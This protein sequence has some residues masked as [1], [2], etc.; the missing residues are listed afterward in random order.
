[1][2]RA[3]SRELFLLFISLFILFHLI[4]L[5]AY[6]WFLVVVAVVLL[7][8]SISGF[9]LVLVFRQFG[10]GIPVQVSLISKMAIRNIMRLFKLSGK[11]KSSLFFIVFC[12]FRGSLFF[13]G[14]RFSGVFVFPGLGFS[15]VES[16]F[17]RGLQSSFFW[18][19]FFLHPHLDLNVTTIGPKCNN[20]WT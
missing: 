2:G 14:L 1:M 17:F 20:T 8:G 4:Y 11:R 9:E 5:F 7:V 10:V 3:Q 16:W 13:R 18:S 12:Y 6:F 15:E 19:S